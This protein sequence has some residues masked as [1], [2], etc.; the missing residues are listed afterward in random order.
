L[1]G[2]QITT[3]D[4]IAAT[5][6]RTAGGARIGWICVSVVTRL[7]AHLKDTIAAARRRASAQASVTVFCVPVVAEFS[8]L[9]DP[10][11]ALGWAAIMTVIGRI[12]IAV[13]AALTGTNN[14]VT[15]ARRNANTQTAIRV[16]CVAV[17]AR[18]IA[19]ITHLKIGTQNAIAAARSDA[20]C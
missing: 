20:A 4:S 8:R 14:P 1:L 12:V 11:A 17:I 10:V 9:N 6:E 18:L 19:W 15:A 2:L 3:N 16:V 13:I 5:S 7:N